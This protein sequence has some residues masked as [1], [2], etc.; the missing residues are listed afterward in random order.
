MPLPVVHVGCEFEGQ[1]L[2]CDGSPIVRGKMIDGE[3][4]TIDGNPI[5][6][7]G[8]I[9]LSNCG[10]MCYSVG[11]SVVWY[12]NSKPVVRIGDPVQGDII[13][14]LVTGSDYVNSD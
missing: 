10:H 11:Q 5:C 12:I 6:V 2:I 3:F 1:C 9:G 4:A 8:S 13:G 7:T 14:K